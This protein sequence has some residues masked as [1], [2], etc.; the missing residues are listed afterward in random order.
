MK[1]LFFVVTT[2]LSFSV[3]AQYHSLLWKI[4]G[5]GLQQPSYLFGT[6]HT[7]DKRVL[8]KGEEVLSYFNKADAYA[9]ELDPKESFN[10]SLLSKLM[11]GKNYSLKKMI[12]ERE[13]LLLDSVVKAQVGFSL[14]LFDNVAPVFI[15]T[16]LEAAGIDSDNESE[17]GDEVLDLLFYRKAKEAKKKTIG[18]ETVDEQLKA[19][20]VLSYEEQADMLVRSIRE[21]EKSKQTMKDMVRFYTEKQLDSIAML[22]DED[23]MPEKFYK[24]LVTDRNKRMATRIGDLMLKQSL[25]IAVGA[26]HLPGD[27]GVIEL[28]RKKGYTVEAE[29]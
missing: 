7:S 17:H 20:N 8:Q 6:M 2:L 29:N 4:S 14:K 16:I 19:L 11:M 28:L 1:K 10:L 13:Y 21:Y 26:L 9:M 27:K 18:I 15:M 22:N 25:F 23:P 12:P 24:A 5:N 3:S